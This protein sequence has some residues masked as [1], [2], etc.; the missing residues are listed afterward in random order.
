MMTS[1]V[2]LRQ[3]QV[4]TKH[5]KSPGRRRDGYK[6]IKKS[7]VVFVSCVTGSLLAQSSILAKN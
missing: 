4:L 3:Q 5:K 1:R 2:G 6:I 7:E